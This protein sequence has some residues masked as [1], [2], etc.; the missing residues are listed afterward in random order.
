MN[1]VVSKGVSPKGVIQVC[2]F[3]VDLPNKPAES[4]AGYTRR[5]GACVVEA[6]R[7]SVRH[8]VLVTGGSAGGEAR[9]GLK[10]GSCSGGTCVVGG[11]VWQGSEHGRGTARLECWVVSFEFLYPPCIRSLLSFSI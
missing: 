3:R 8:E 1:F 7:A 11:A 10:P 6:S 4:H 5:G 2:V 9:T